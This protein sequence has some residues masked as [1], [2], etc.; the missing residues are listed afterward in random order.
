MILSPCT[1]VAKDGLRCS[2]MNGLHGLTLS[3]HLWYEDGN[4]ILVATNQAFRVHRGVLSQHSAVFRDL[5]TVPQPSSALLVDGCA[6]VHL[7]D[8]PLHLE[9]LLSA[10]YDRSYLQRIAEVASGILSLSHKYDIESFYEEAIYRLLEDY[11]VTFDRFRS[12]EQ[13]FLE[14]FEAAHHAGSIFI[15]NAAR[16][17]RTPELLELLPLAF[18]LCSLLDGSLLVK[19]VPRSNGELE[20]LSADDLLRCINGKEGLMKAN[21]AA[22]MCLGP[23]TESL[24]DDC[25][26]FETC[27]KALVAITQDALEADIFSACDALT[28]IDSWIDE[29]ARKY[30][31]C[32]RCAGNIRSVH[33]DAQKE[34]WDT[35]IDIFELREDL[36]TST[37][38]APSGR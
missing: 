2:T 9:F 7:A 6:V 31:L 4:V 29:K 8:D 36:P 14:P 13:Y 5:F 18:Y 32:E 12:T 23:F 35:L 19:G 15:I 25:K 20:K 38:L 3:E 21:A 34:V 1:W 37:D 11:P 16:R 17:I 28:N 33:R 24:A 30:A 10:M 26:V 27:K 22:T